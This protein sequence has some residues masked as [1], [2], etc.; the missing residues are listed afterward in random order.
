M[1]HL[2]RL[3][4][5]AVVVLVGSGMT[6]CGGGGG[7]GSPGPAPTPTPPPPPPPPPP[8]PTGTLNG[9]VFSASTG[10]AVNGASASVA[11][12]AAVT[13]SATGSFQLAGVPASERVVVRV[14]APG[15]VDTLAV[16]AVRSGSVSLARVTLLPVGS[17]A[18]VNPATAVSVA[19]TDSPAQ[20]TAAANSF[21]RADNGAAPPG[22]LTVRLTAIDPARDADRMPGDFSTGTGTTVQQIESFGA[23][24]VD[25][26]DAQNNRYD[27][28]SGKTATV[29][30]PVSTREASPPTTIPLFYLDETTG[31][32][33]E[34]GSATLAGSGT[35]RY[36][37]GTVS[38]FSY[39]NADR[40]YETVF[41]N[42]CVQTAAGIRTRNR[43]V[44]TD[45]LDYTGTG[46]AFS[47]A[48]G[49]FRV[50]LRKNSQAVLTV[51]GGTES[52]APTVVG[53]LAADTTLPQCLVERGS[54]GNVP[55]SI[56][57]QPFSTTVDEGSLAKFVVV[58]DGGTPLHYQWKRRGVD[59]PGAVGSSYILFATGADN[60]AVFS[61]VITNGAGTVTSNG[62][63]LTVN[64]PNTPPA[65][66]QQPGN[67]S[68]QVGQVA[69]FSVTAAGALPLSYQWRRGG[70]AISG[71]TAASYTTPATALADDGALFDVVVTNNL[72]SVNSA[73]ATLTVA[74]APPVAGKYKRELAALMAATY[75]AGCTNAAGAGAGPIVIAANGDLS[76]DGGSMPMSSLAATVSL[77]NGYTFAGGPTLGN[78]SLQ[79]T[80]IN[81]VFQISTTRS[82]TANTSS[83]QV[84]Q[85]TPLTKIIGC[86][87]GITGGIPQPNI[88]GLVA[89]WLQGTTATFSCTVTMGSSSTT[90]SLNFAVAGGQLTLGSVTLSLATP[91]LVADS[92]LANDVTFGGAAPPDSL[93]AY[94]AVYSNSTVL[95]VSRNVTSRSMLVAYSTPTVSYTCLGDRAP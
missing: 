4:G 33:I 1:N 35:T 49:D 36:Y 25:I 54:V 27:L 53:P 76:W 9:L 34:Q 91:T 63:T 82:T 5:V 40:P 15:F 13:T 39:W 24:A 12:L 55:P 32:W 72:G 19:A 71:A 90:Q 84:S 18:S 45:G 94:S 73:P 31:R 69:I 52:V 57:A 21:A 44:K 58:A 51:Q 47:D 80:S 62:A 2:Q 64:V 86:N 77:S 81:R 74:S 38:H 61:V 28:A 83:A 10:A 8:G 37:E 70:T 43:T 26:R 11:G 16:A 89:N 92:A 78:H 50:A 75:G 17:T 60:G 22:S 30:I 42:G 87:P 56:L 59:I 65:I 48:N 85:N 20:I 95:S 88:V 67:V 93:F 66:T 3:F 14:S 41:I 68:V 46:N 7:G 79:D 23:V 6:A 29:R